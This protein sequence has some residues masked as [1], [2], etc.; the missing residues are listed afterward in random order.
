MDRLELRVREAGLEEDRRRHGVVV[1]ELLQIAHRLRDLLRRRRHEARVPGPAPADPVLRRPELARILVAAARA[2]DELRV[3]LA[4]QAVRE[5]EAS[6]DP[7][8]PVVE[9]L[10]VVQRLRDLGARHS[11]C[12]LVLEEEELRE[13]ALRPLDLRGQ[14]RL[15]ADVRVEELIRVR[16]EQGDP[17]EPP[18]RLVGAVGELL[19]RRDVERRLGRQRPR[20]EDRVRSRRRSPSSGRHRRARPIPS[21]ALVGAATT[22]G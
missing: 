17:V 1:Q 20:M 22:K 11:G 19:K 7:V 18:E 2:L 4:E 14:D 8:E 6:L 13:R 21:E 3:D 16:Q 15:L 10:D 5:R 9:R 12:V